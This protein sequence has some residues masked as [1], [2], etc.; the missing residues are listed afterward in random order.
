MIGRPASESWQ[1]RG[2]TA[3]IAII[4]VVRERTGRPVPQGATSKSRPRIYLWNIARNEGPTDEG[5]M[6]EERKNPL[7]DLFN[8]LASASETS[9][10]QFVMHVTSGGYAAARRR[11]FWGPRSGRPPALQRSRV[12]GKI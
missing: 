3:T 4:S 9:Y 2:G 11:W 5:F 12:K 6:R 1:R 8:N 10:L 7:K